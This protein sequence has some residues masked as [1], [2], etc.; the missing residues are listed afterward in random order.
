MKDFVKMLQKKGAKATNLAERNIAG[1]S[2][3]GNCHCNCGGAGNCNCGPGNC[4]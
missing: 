3:A 2:A 1:T 4:R